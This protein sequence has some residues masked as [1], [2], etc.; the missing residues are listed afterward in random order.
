MVLISPPQPYLLAHHTQVPLGLLYLSAVI[1]RE[2]PDVGVV[3]ADCTAMRV[4]EAA[5]ALPKADVYGYSAVSLDFPVCM[6]LKEKLAARWPTASHIIGGPHATAMPNEVASAG[7]DSVFIREAES[8]ILAYID[9]FCAGHTS[10]CYVPG[11][12]TPLEWLP[13]PDREALDWIGGRVLANSADNK[14]ANVMASRGCP[15]ACAF[16]ASQVM[17]KRRVRWRTPEDVVAEMR[18]CVEKYQTEVFRFSDDNMTTSRSWTERFCE[19]VTP[20]GV[21]WRL[22]FRVDSITMDLVQRMRR[23]GCVEAGLGIESFDPNV[24]KALDKRVTAEQSIAAIK[25]LHEAGMGARV[26]LMIGTPGET[27]QKTVTDNIAALESVR[28]Q[29]VYVTL[30][31]FTPLPGCPAWDN[32]GSYGIK[33]LSKNFKEYNLCFVRREQ[34]GE[35]K[36]TIRPLVSIEGMSMGQQID[37]ASKMLAYLESLPEYWKGREEAKRAD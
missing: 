14:S 28:G 25:M 36:R 8:S 6:D 5:E 10:G 1:K 31:M 17:W 34:D 3:V 30:T 37:N 11:A 18:E 16:C 22:S 32:P 19:L 15:Y 2:R 27:Y 29:Y 13:R 20:L 26:L 4:D 35:I 9:D 23:A 7:F 24:L 12:W 21:E 33:L